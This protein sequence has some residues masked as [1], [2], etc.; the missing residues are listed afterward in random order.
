MFSFFHVAQ[1]F[2]PRLRKWQARTLKQVTSPASRSDFNEP[3]L[4]AGELSVVRRRS[5]VGSAIR[6]GSPGQRSARATATA[7]AAKRC[8][9]PCSAERPWPRE[10]QGNA[11]VVAGP[12]AHRRGGRF[13][14]AE[15]HRNGRTR[16]RRGI[17]TFVNFWC[18]LR[19]LIRERVRIPP[20]Q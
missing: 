3:W 8:K 1:F 11:A 18:S 13:A 12:K 5:A 9:R 20:R 7:E 2:A 19:S 16:A 17:S 14:E 15:P 4:R 10:W 6:A